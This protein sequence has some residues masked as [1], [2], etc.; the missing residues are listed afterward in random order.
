[1]HLVFH[2]SQLK[3]TIGAS[4]QVTTTLPSD[5]ALR[6]TPK[7]VLQTRSVRRGNQAVQQVLIKW[8]KLPSTLAT[9]ADYEAIR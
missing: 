5:F 6:L 3:K 1:V 8:N 2:V 9:W 4:N 7:Q